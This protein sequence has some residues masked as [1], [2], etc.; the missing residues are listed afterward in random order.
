MAYA[1]QF[2]T[3][4]II[5]DVFEAAD[6]ATLESALAI[7]NDTKAASPVRGGHRSFQQP[8]KIAGRRGRQQIIGGTLRRSYTTTTPGQEGDPT[9]AAHGTVRDGF[10]LVG[11]WLHYAYYVE[12][13]TS[14]MPPRP[15]FQPAIDKNMPLWFT[16]F[17][18]HYLSIAPEFGAA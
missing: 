8:R 2:E 16:R 1:I 12:R 5:A 4:R 10:I 3:A 6:R 18:R 9:G 14:K 11:S 13:G 15:H 7:E 17:R